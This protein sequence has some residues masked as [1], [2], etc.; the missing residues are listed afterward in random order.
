MIPEMVILLDLY[1]FEITWN[2]YKFC[3]QEIVLAKNN[4]HEIK[5]QHIKAISIQQ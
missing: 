3:K 4:G 2:V 5:V 1:D